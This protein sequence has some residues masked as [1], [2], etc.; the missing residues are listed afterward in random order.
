MNSTCE[1]GT[2]GVSPSERVLLDF[3]AADDPTQG[4]QEGSSYHR[5]KSPVLTSPAAPPA[6]VS[7]PLP[8]LYKGMKMVM[9]GFGVAGIGGPGPGEKLP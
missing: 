5:E 8:P 4:E 3:D 6:C 7:A 2:K 1:S 9:I